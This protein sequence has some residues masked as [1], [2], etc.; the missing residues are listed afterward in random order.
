MPELYL[1]LAL[2]HVN[3]PA[4]SDIADHMIWINV[5]IAGIDG[6][7]RLQGQPMS[8]NGLKDAHMMPGATQDT[9]AFVENLHES[10][11]DVLAYPFIE[12]ADQEVA[13][14]FRG[15]TPFCD[16]SLRMF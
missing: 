6:A 2:H 12:Y 13:I 14:L 5:V 10:F 1:L 9:Q 15:Y 16:K 8:A 3:E 11:T 4:V 7:V